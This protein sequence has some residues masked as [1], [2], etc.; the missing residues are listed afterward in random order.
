MNLVDGE[1]RYLRV[2]FSLTWSE[3]QPEATEILEGDWWDGGSEPG[4][5][6][7]EENAA[8]ILRLSPGD[9]VEWSIDGRVQSARVANVRRT[10]GTR[11]GANNQFI[12]TPGTL[13]AFPGIYYGALRV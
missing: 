10:D 5:V 4:L 6:S 7:V 13:D 8:G 11:A 3:E 2:Q 12:L 1:R 9:T